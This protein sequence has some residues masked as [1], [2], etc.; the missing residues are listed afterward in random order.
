MIRQIFTRLL[1][2]VALV[3]AAVSPGSATFLTL[4]GAG[5]TGALAPAPT[6]VN[7]AT[8]NLAS[9]TSCSVSMP[10][11]VVVGNELIM[12]VAWGTGSGITATPPAGWSR[13]RADHANAG[14]GVY[15]K[16]ADGTEGSTQTVTLSSGTRMTVITYQ[17]SG[18]DGNPPDTA[19]YT[20]CSTTTCSPP[21]TT[22]SGGTANIAV[23]AVAGGTTSAAQTVSS[24]PSGYTNGVVVG[25]STNPRPYIAAAQTTINGASSETP[26]AFT[27]GLTPTSSGGWGQTVIISG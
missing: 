2:A 17:I 4:T 13:A 26:G 27:L 5:A 1:L 10:A 25:T 15:Y 18:W 21:T 11:S 24:Y 8:S 22:V 12:L 7:N 20:T 9:C 3:A 23:L 16:T 6:I 19:A 14:G